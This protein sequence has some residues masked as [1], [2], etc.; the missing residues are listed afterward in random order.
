MIVPSRKTQVVLR[1]RG[2]R[3][4]GEKMEPKTPADDKSRKITV[5]MD[6]DRIKRLAKASE[7]PGKHPHIEDDPFPV[8]K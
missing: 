4:G 7:R 1:G 2:A 6:S 5:K 3:V 8:K